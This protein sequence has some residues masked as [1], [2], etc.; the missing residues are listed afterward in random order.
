VLAALIGYFLGSCPEA[1]GVVVTGPNGIPIASS[2]PP[3]ERIQLIAAT[4]MANLAAWAGS[5]VAANLRLPGM[6]E[7]TLG[8]PTWK[9]ILAS[10]PS[11]SA[12]LIVTLV[13]G[14]DEAP[15]HRALPGL[16]REVDR[17]LAGPAI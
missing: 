1:T 6:S 4:A 11:L 15:I 10:T 13:E 5:A 14:A 16:L 8:G 17:S 12:G 3:E 2:L 9:I 7:V